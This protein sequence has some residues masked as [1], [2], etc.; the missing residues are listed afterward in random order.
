MEAVTRRFWRSFESLR[1]E[2]ADPPANVYKGGTGCP[3][4]VDKKPPLCGVLISAFGD[5]FAI[6]FGTRRSTHSKNLWLRFPFEN[7]K[8]VW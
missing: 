1:E 7:Q 5:H 8:V 3:Q 4:H 2:A 6:A